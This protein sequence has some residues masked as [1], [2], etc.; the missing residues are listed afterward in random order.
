VAATYSEL[1]GKLVGEDWTNTV[2]VEL[3]RL[4][5]VPFRE[6]GRVYWC[7]PQSLKAAS[8]LRAFLEEIGLVLVIAEVESEVKTVVKDV[9]SESVAD[10]LAYLTQEVEAFDG[11]QK[12]STYTRRLEEY[13]RLRQKAILYRD[14]LGIGV[15]QA[16]NALEELEARVGSMLD[17]RKTT[18]VH[19]NGVNSPAATSPTVPV[20]PAVKGLKFSGAIFDNAGFKEGIHRFTSGDAAAIRSIK[21]LET[22]GIAGKW[23]QAGSVQVLLKN[24]GPKGADVSIEVKS[25]ADIATAAS[26][27]ACLGISLNQ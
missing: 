3:E 27:L 6:D 18:V 21:A 1:R 16:V 5:A 10:Q 7:P 15:E 2:T 23:Q 25:D 22:M 26:S 24:S 14:S 17:I 19:R 13:Q 11:K 8:K 20:T 4:G 9:V 12:P